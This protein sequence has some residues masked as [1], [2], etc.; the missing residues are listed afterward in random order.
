[1]IAVDKA[2]NY[3]LIFN[4][5]GMYRGWVEGRDQKFHTRIFKD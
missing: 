4:S 1:L 2:G 3:E 5:T